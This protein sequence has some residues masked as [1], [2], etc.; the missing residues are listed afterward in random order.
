MRREGGVRAGHAR[1]GWRRPGRG[2]Q[3]LRDG[4]AGAV[5]FRKGRAARPG[6][7]EGEARRE[8][9]GRSLGAA[10]RPGGRGGRGRRPRRRE[11]GRSGPAS[12]LRRPRGRLR[13]LRAVTAARLSS[14]SSPRGE[15]LSGTACGGG[16]EPPRGAR[17]P[18]RS[19]VSGPEAAPH[20]G[21]GRAA[22]ARGSPKNAVSPPA[23]LPPPGPVW[24]AGALRANFFRHGAP[25]DGLFLRPGATEGR[26]P[27]AAGRPGAAGVPGRPR[28]LPR[29]GA[30]PAAPRQSDRRA[31]GLGQLQQL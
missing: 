30:G 16:R 18:T 29:R 3:L 6:C 19:F 20:G 9:P 23:S 27:Q 24:P 7:G 25:G 1:S 12:P 31:G 22:G 15:E 11:H 5:P 8:A 17:I 10:P 13:V 28:P 26:G 2:T 14:A 21:S 4:R